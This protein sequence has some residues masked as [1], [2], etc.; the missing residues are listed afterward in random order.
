MTLTK[1]WMF[2]LGTVA[3]GM[4]CV[5]KDSPSVLPFTVQVQLEGSEKSLLAGNS[6]EA[7][8]AENDQIRAFG[9]IDRDGN[10]HLE[11]YYRGKLIGG[12][13][14]GNYQ[15][16]IILNDDD[17]EARKKALKVIPAKFFQFKTSGLKIQIPSDTPPVLKLPSR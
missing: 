4:G 11:T 16:R 3:F 12:A 2:G 5:E 9:S 10:A 7:A 1:K 6:I 14:P 13:Q 15:I 8:H 17:P